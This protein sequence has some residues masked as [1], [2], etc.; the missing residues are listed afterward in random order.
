[1]TTR[2]NFTSRIKQRR[3]NAL[4]QREA[5]L[6]KA[7]DPKLYHAPVPEEFKESKEWKRVREADISR[8][9]EEIQTLKERIR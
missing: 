1:M 8:I 9:K 2:K 5:D 6:K 4:W 3:E 7:G